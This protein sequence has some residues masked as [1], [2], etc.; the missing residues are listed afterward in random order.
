LNSKRKQGKKIK[1]ICSSFSPN[2]NKGFDIYNFLDK[3][4]DF[5]KYEMIFVGSS[6]Y[7][8]NNIKCHDPV[9]SSELAEFL[10]EGDLYVTGAKNDCCSNSLIEALSCGLP[11]LVLNSGGSPEILKGGGLLFDSNADIIGKIDTVATSLGEYRKLIEVDRIEE[12]SRQYISFFEK[13]RSGKS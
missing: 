8:F 6:P 9:A 13:V 1:L 10:R 12:I 3:N 7:K 11:S 2:L 5:N 4:L